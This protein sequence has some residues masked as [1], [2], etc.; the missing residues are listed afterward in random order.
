MRPLLPALL[1]ALAACASPSSTHDAAAPAPVRD[2]LRVR[3]NALLRVDTYT[4]NVSVS[5]ALD[6]PVERAWAA[7]PG[8]LQGLGFEI[9]QVDDSLRRITALRPRTR[10]AFGGKSHA[11]LLRCG[12]TGGRPNA[13]IYD[14]ELGVTTTLAAVGAGTTLTTEVNAMAIPNTTSGNRLRCTAG[15]AIGEIIADALA[16]WA[17]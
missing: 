3:G 9:T 17:K 4:P 5:R 15:P 2:E 1:L 10:R 6:V 16:E 13:S 8:V 12:D 11:Q 14:I 7:I